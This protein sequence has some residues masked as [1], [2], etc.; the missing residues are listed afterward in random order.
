MAKIEESLLNE[1]TSTQEAMQRAQAELGHIAILELR[2]NH[3][4]N[5]YAAGEQKLAEIGQRIED[6]YGPGN[7]NIATGEHEPLEQE[8]VPAEEAAE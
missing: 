6:K 3:L 5:Q 1:L 7:V 4:L 8:T 2:K